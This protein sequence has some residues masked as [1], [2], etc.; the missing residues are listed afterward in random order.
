MAVEFVEQLC[1]VPALQLGERGVAVLI[2]CGSLLSERRRFEPWGLQRG[3]NG[4]RG[5]NLLNGKELPGKCT[6]DVAV[7]DR[8]TVSTPGGGGWGSPDDD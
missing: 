3:S 4:A 6:L 5:Q 2:D 1:D 7:G 8:L